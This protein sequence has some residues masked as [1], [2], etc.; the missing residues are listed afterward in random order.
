MKMKTMMNK[1][2]ILRE[3]EW[4]DS[5]IENNIEYVGSSV[6]PDECINNRY[7]IP[8]IEMVYF[9]KKELMKVTQ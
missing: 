6:V 8:V 2:E 4:Y 5:L 1:E 9:W 7:R 3:L